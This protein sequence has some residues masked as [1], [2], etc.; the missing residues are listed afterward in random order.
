MKNNLGGVALS[1]MTTKDDWKDFGV[2]IFG[3]LR[4]LPA[5]VNNLL[6]NKG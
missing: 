5:Q 4:I 6:S 3:D 1:T 2:S